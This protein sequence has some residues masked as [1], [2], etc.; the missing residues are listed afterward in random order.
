LSVYTDKKYL[1]MLSRRLALFNAKSE[2]LFNFRCVLCGDSKKNKTKCRAYVYRQKSDMCFTCH[3]CGKTMSFGNF[4]KIVDKAMYDDYLMERFSE[5]SG[6]NVVKPNFDEFK[7]AGPLRKLQDNSIDLPTIGELPADHFAKKY[8]LARQIPKE[9]HSRIYYASDFKDFVSHKVPEKAENLID[10]EKRIVLPFWDQNKNLLGFQ[11][12]A[13]SNS[14][15]KYI[16]VK[17]DEYAKKV[18]G[19]DLADFSKVVPV[20]EGPIDSLFIK[21]SLASMDA[22]LQNIIP[23]V[24]NVDAEYVFVFDNEPR[25]THVHRSMRKTIDAGLSIVIWPSSVTEKDINEM[26]LAGRDVDKLISDRTYSGILA[27]LEFERWKKI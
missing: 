20:V 19:L 24:G 1:M 6:G 14:S 25:N 9:Y 15:V 22:T 5:E 8:I 2:Y 23:I 10:N 11:G 17:L 12:R 18:Y 13:L 27:T 4:L 21:N 3:N 16:T 26:I 7:T